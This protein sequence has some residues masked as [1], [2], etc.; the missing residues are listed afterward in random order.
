MTLGADGYIYSTGG[1]NGNNIDFDPGPGVF[2][3]SSNGT[4]DIFISKLSPSGDFVW[5]KSVGSTS[6]DEARGIAVDNNN[7]VYVAGDY[8]ATIDIDPGPGVVNFIST[9]GDGFLLKLNPAGLYVNAYR[10]TTA[11]LDIPY[12]M[13][14]KNG[15][16]Y[17]TTYM[18][19][20]AA[21][22]KFDP[23]LNV[24]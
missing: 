2:N 3:I 16:L 7:N 5:A 23:D 1:F 11:G 24:I 22:T 10:I 15:F 13:S 6:I 19:I 20:K 12:A 14:L 8:N 9:S 17:V 4:S 18:N 21:V